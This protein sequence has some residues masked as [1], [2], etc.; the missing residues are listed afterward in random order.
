[1]SGDASGGPQPRSHQG[2]GVFQAA[3]TRACRVRWSRA[4]SERP[5]PG[6]KL[7]TSTPDWPCLWARAVPVM[8]ARDCDITGWRRSE[9]G[10][11]GASAR[12]TWP[13]P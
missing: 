1:M 9:K 4:A 3:P 11:P 2:P 7:P 6:G 5:P 13:G 8:S 12:G 10:V